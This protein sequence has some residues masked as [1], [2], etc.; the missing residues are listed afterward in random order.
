MFGY[1]MEIQRY[2]GQIRMK[3]DGPLKDLICMLPHLKSEL[4]FLSLL[5]TYTNKLNT[6]S[7]LWHCKH[8]C[9]NTFAPLVASPSGIAP[10]SFL[11]IL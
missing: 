2:Q 3:L 8:L 4:G 10:E 5:V 9:L 7:T 1:L 11:P 6:C